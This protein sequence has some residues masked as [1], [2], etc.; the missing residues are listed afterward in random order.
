[1]PSGSWPRNVYCVVLYFYKYKYKYKYKYRRAF[2][3]KY[4]EWEDDGL[5]GD[6]RPDTG[7][8]KPNWGD[9]GRPRLDDNNIK[10][11]FI[12][13]YCGEGPDPVAL[14]WPPRR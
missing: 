4:N 11:D 3:V 10:H 12:P 9:E 8:W 7:S 13:S 2:E 5:H 6:H 14:D 1:M